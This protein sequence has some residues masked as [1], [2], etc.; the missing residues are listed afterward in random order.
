MTAHWLTTRTP[1]VFGEERILL[2]QR[3]HEPT[4]Q[5]FGMHTTGTHE[6]AKETDPMHLELRFEF[7]PQRPERIRNVK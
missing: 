3:A 5:I 6:R 4:L 1:L 2:A 7:R